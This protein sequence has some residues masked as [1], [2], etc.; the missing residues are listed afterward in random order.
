MKVKYTFFMISY[1]YAFYAYVNIKLFCV[2]NSVTY[3]NYSGGTIEPINP[4]DPY[5]TLSYVDNNYIFYFPELMHNF[6]DY[7]CI[8]IVNLCWPGG[9]SFYGANINEYNI[10]I[11]NYTNFF[12]CKGCNIDTINKYKIEGE[13]NNRPFIYT[14]YFDCPVFYMENKFCLKP[15]NDISIFNTGE[16]NINKKYYKG[17]NNIKYIL[18]NDIDYFYID[19]IF[20]INHNPEYK[21]DLDTISYRIKNITNKKGHLYNGKNEIFLNT[22]F[23]PEHKLKYN[24]STFDDGYIMTINIETRTRLIKN[25][26]SYLTC[27]QPANLYIYIPQKNCSM[28]NYSNNFCQN[29]LENYIKNENKCYHK[30]E[31]FEN[32]YYNESLNS[33]EKCDYNLNVFIC[34]I[35]PKGTFIKE[36]YNDYLICEWKNNKNV[37]ECPEGMIYLNLKTGKCYYN[38]SNLELMREKYEINKEFDELNKIIDNIM[39]NFQENPNLKNEIL[40]EKNIEIKG[41]DTNIVI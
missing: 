22:V 3:I 15:N 37:I 25:N 20:S 35:C 26:I 33:W 31:K 9:F 39:N 17:K 24:K 36:Y 29:C 13:C 5:S 6:K 11:L 1:I 2:D 30:S 32:L 40:N 14:S 12:I 10:T 34:S 27:E 28:V 8:N 16:N 4:K 18:I 23:Y 21:I 19:E 38:V 41:L 7:I